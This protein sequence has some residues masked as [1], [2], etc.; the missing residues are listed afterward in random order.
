MMFQKGTETSEY[1]RG[2]EIEGRTVKMRVTLTKNHKKGT[3][4]VVATL[5]SEAWAYDET[6]KA[7]VMENYD[8]MMR[9][10]AQ[11]GRAWQMEYEAEQATD[12]EPKLFDDEPGHQSYEG[13]APAWGGL[14][15]GL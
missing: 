13:E 15:E 7:A 2:V 5:N 12:G 14:R 1:A 10:A 8:A 9:T 11:D 3:F 6:D 4:K